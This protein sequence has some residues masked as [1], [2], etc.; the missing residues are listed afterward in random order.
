V[1][2]QRLKELLDSISEIRCCPTHDEHVEELLAYRDD[3][4]EMWRERNKDNAEEI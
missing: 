1:T 4:I 2:T 3:L